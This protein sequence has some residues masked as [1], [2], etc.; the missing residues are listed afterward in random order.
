MSAPSVQPIAP[1]EYGALLDHCS[2]CRSCRSVPERECPQAGALLQE[3]S[4]AQRAERGT[5]HG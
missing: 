3:W 4:T 1:V 2:G 5:R